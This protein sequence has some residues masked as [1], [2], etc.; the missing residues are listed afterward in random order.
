M[1]SGT[2]RV[3]YGGTWRMMTAPSVSRIIARSAHVTG[4]TTIRAWLNACTYTFI[5]KKHVKGISSALT[6]FEW[7]IGHYNV[8]MKVFD[9]ILLYNY[10]ITIVLLLCRGILT[11]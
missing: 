10:I 2:R 5:G 4:P 1:W 11:L 3:R 9:Y 8:Y 6:G 7:S